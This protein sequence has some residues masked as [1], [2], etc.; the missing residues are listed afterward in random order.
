MTLFDPAGPMAAQGTL[1][2]LR[3]RYESDMEAA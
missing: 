3:G 2:A 1:R